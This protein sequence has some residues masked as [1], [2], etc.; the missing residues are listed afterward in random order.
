[1]KRERV[2]DLAAELASE[3]D[4]LQRVSETVLELWQTMPKDRRERSIH[5]AAL[6]LHL[7]NF[8]TGVEKAFERIADELNGG[9]PTGRDWRARLLHSMTLELPKVRPPVISKETESALREFLA[10]R[11]VVRNIYAFELDSDR[12]GLLMR[13]FGKTF[14]LFRGDMLEF[15]GVLRALTDEDEPHG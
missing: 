9:A 5:E 3:V 13:R 6:A 2:I 10:F 8:Y 15:V 11:H 12:L 14:E 1:M 7:H 4:A